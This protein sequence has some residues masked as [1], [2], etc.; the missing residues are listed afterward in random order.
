MRRDEPGA[1]R[2]WRRLLIRALP[3]EDRKSFPGE[4]EE[5]Y[6]RRA[7]T[8]GPGAARRWYGR[9]VMRLA[10][11]RA[12]TT[13]TTILR[14]GFDMDG[15]RRDVAYAFRRLLKAPAFT[16]IAVASLALGIGAN[17]A[18][19]SL[20]NAVILRPS[21]LEAPDEL[22]EIY[23]RQPGFSHGTVSYLD[24]LDI[25][26]RTDDVF[27]DVATSR[28]AL[29]NSYDGAGAAEMHPSE[30]VSGNYFQVQGIQAS[31]GRTILPEDDVRDG[32]A[33]V[34]VLDHRFWERRFGGDPSVVGTEMR[35]GGHPVTI[36]GV[37]ERDF[38]GSMRGLVPDIYAPVTLAPLID[39][40]NG[41]FESRGNQSFFSRGRLR[42]GATFAQAEAAAGRVTEWL[43]EAYPD[44][45]L[46]DEELVLVSTADV[47]VNPM[48]DRVLV[49]ALGLLLGV[50]GVVLVI[51][52]ANLASFLLA[53]AAD[54]KR[55]VAV[56][57]ALGASRG[58]LVR[59]LLTETVILALVGGVAGLG[60]AAWLTGWVETAELPLPLPITLDL[61]LDGSVLLFTLLV[62][63]GAGVVFGLTPALQ[64]TRPAL[65]PTLKNEA[66]GDPPRRFNARNVLVVGQVALSLVLLVGAGLLLRSMLA[67]Q[68][69]DPGF[70]AEPAAMAQ[71]SLG[72]L[73][74]QEDAAMVAGV[75]DYVD[76][77]AA[78]PGVSTVG[79]ASNI[80]L[81]TLSSSSRY[82]SVDGIDPPAGRDRWQIAY[83]AVSEG[84]LDAMGIELLEGRGIERTDDADS[85]PVAVV[86]RAFAD[87]FFPDGGAVGG[88]VRFT[89]GEARVVGVVETVKESSLSEPPTPFIYSAFA[90]DPQSFFFVVAETPTA[91]PRAVAL[92]LG[93]IGRDV[94]PMVRIFGQSTMEGHLAI[95]LFPA[96]ASALIA[97]I[98]AGL[99]LTL[100][101]IGLYGVVSYAVSRKTREVGIRVSLGAQGGQVVRMLMADGLRLVAV[102]GVIGIALSAGFAVVL[103]RFLY[104]IGAFDPWAFV[105][106]G[107]LLLAVA[108]LASWVPARR[109]VRVD[110]VRALK[111][112]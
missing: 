36:V 54:R 98:F 75:R 103:S 7:E 97:A 59:Q 58:G 57:L 29:L 17:T 102:G 74:G 67:R 107:G 99:A 28:F 52:C 6:R 76:R 49:P 21:A 79:I 69:I 27:T 4:L 16:L 50:V 18:I 100:A 101:C 3:E 10:L 5:L 96:R 62:S 9:Q 87:T 32:A 33:P 91:D 30:M 41:E 65:A 81:N 68:A 15:L 44:Q 2:L 8:R 25:R 85:E 40:G 56:R 13:T 31:V 45:W 24:Y 109:A 23:L 111:A 20:V 51:A 11:R 78:L 89:S 110:P 84:Y 82:V 37:I 61:S 55:E 92:E 38:Q 104:G 66:T 46:S 90:Q 26:E 95:V 86:N 1:P 39:P 53:R 88:T 77:V 48:I 112:D 34:V 105:G 19:F 73:E 80:H 70:G 106:T 71:I 14:T 94:D 63:L 60:L 72:T 64:A 42:E 47:V 93:R 43:R 83:A 35:V 12:W 22:V 108:V